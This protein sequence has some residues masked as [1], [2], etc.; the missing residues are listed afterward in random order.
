LLAEKKI[1][2]CKW[3]YQIKYH[4]DGSVERHKPRLVV[5]DNRQVEGIDFTEIFA[6]VAEII[7]VQTFLAGA[8]TKG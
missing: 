2:D 7:S 8:A 3:V 5:L 1:I 6:P 4:S